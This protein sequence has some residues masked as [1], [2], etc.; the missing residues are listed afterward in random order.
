MSGAGRVEYFRALEMQRSIASDVADPRMTSA[1]LRSLGDSTGRELRPAD[2]A[3]LHAAC[4]DA[5]NEGATYFWSADLLALA[6]GAAKTLP[7]FQAFTE[8]PLTRDGFA[9]FE[10]PRTI[11]PE[12]DEICGLLWAT[13]NIGTPTR[14]LIGIFLWALS[15]VP[16]APESTDGWMVPWLAGL[17]PVSGTWDGLLPEVENPTSR[18][19]AAMFLLQSQTLVMAEPRT[20]PRSLR[21][22]LERDGEAIRD[23]IVVQLR[24]LAGT[25]HE[26]G[27][28]E[29]QHQWIVSGHWRNHYWPK[30]RR[31]VPTWISPYLKGPDGAPLLARADRVFAV[32]R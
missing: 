9:W 22:R 3:M 30:Q 4:R 25:G 18:F 20:P 26:H 29:W 19:A 8:L 17:L 1:M 24:R 21:R 5:L 23:I 27:S 6:M 15:F 16:R 12:D 14:E 28:Q 13:V 32:V 7:S 31:H 2:V 11:R 10:E